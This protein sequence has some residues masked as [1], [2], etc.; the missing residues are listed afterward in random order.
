VAELSEPEPT[1]QAIALPYTTT[2]LGAA[3][4]VEGA[5]LTGWA[6]EQ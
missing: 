1:E 3:A 5:D 6:G 4:I 2:V